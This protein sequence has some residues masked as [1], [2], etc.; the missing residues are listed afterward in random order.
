MTKTGVRRAPL[1]RRV[2]DN[3]VI[4]VNRCVVKFRDCYMLSILSK[5]GVR[6]E[7]GGN[8]GTKGEETPPFI[9]YLGKS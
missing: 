4:T 3:P 8:S 9:I 2:D 7:K 6:G 1:S 5:V